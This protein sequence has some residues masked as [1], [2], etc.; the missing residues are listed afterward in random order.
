MYRCNIEIIGAG[1]ASG[2]GEEGGDH[3]T[4]RAGCEEP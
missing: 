2:S 4:S 1:G 3:L